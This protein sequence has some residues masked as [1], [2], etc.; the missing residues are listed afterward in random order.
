MNNGLRGN[1]VEGK[2][3]VDDNVISTSKTCHNIP[4]VHSRECDAVDALDLEKFG[5]LLLR[6]SAETD[7]ALT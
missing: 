7:I 5:L 3:S 2:G 6:T 4:A 1:G